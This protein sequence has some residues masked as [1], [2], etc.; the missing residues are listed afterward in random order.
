MWDLG[1]HNDL[2][3]A[4][5]STQQALHKVQYDI[6]VNDVRKVL[7]D[8]SRNSIKFR[9]KYSIYKEG[10]YIM[11]QEFYNNEINISNDKTVQKLLDFYSIEHNRVYK[12]ML[13]IVDDKDKTI[14][15]IKYDGYLLEGKDM[16]YYNL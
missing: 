13:E 14:Y 1:L 2:V 4:F 3:K 16:E 6:E 8:L 9:L 10:G 11:Q 12:V 7:H 5:K 15:F